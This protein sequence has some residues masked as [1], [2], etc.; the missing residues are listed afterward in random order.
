MTLCVPQCQNS[1]SDSPGSSFSSLYWCFIFRFVDLTYYQDDDIVVFQ[2]VNNLECLGAEY[3]LTTYYLSINIG[4]LVIT[5][6]VNLSLAY[7]SSRGR[8]VETGPDDP[9]RCVTPLLYTNIGETL[10]QSDHHHHHPILVLTLLEFF[11]T[12]VGAYFTIKDFMRCIDQEHE[13]TVI[14]GEN[15][16]VSLNNHSKQFHPSCACDNCL[17]LAASDSEDL[18]G[19]LFV[20]SLLPSQV[21]RGAQFVG[22]S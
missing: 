2:E 13:R 15:Y 4:L 17:V 8:I 5:C 3:Q 9:R 1:S 18:P 21:R 20:S 19:G 10:D 7:H 14:V 16:N 12:V 6:I 11:W 22:V